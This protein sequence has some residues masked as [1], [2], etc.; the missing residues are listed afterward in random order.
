MPIQIF[1]FPSHYAIVLAAGKDK[2][3]LL[4]SNLIFLSSKLGPLAKTDLDEK[5]IFHYELCKKLSEAHRNISILNH[6]A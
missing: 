2:V 1:A 6:M 4:V 5:P 3:F